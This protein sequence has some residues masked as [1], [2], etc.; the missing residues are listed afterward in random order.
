LDR[1]TRL[2]EVPFDSRP[3]GVFMNRLPSGDCTIPG[4]LP[5]VPTWTGVAK[6]SVGVAPEDAVVNKGLTL[7][8][9]TVAAPATR[10]GSRPRLRA[11]NTMEV[12]PAGSDV[13]DG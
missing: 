12:L 6:L 1:K 3:S 9:T 13:P 11:I 5:P 7:A 10:R 2:G 8:A 4:S